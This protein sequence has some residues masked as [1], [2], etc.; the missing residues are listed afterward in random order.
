MECKN[1]KTTQLIDL[2][3]KFNVCTIKGNH[4]LTTCSKIL[5]F[6]LR[7]EIFTYN[8]LYVPTCA[9][10]YLLGRNINYH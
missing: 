1:R 3:R 6:V 7:C 5:F 4:D 8:K 9:I 10:K 2:F